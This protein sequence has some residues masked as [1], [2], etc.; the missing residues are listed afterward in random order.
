MTV[1]KPVAPSPPAFSNGMDIPTFGITPAFS[2]TTAFSFI[3]IYPFFL[4]L[5]VRKAA[6]CEGFLKRYLIISGL[7]CQLHL[8]GFARK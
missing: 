7:R 3:K 2:P 6:K 5:D 1:E 8:S 4:P